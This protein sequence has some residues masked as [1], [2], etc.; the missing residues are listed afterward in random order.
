M[1][2]HLRTKAVLRRYQIGLYLAHTMMLSVGLV[3]C[4]AHAQWITTALLIVWLSKTAR[5]IMGHNSTLRTPLRDLVP[6]TIGYH[7]M[8]WRERLTLIPLGILTLAQ[9]LAAVYGAWYVAAVIFLAI[10]FLLLV[11][12]PI[13]P[14]V[15]LV[16]DATADE[17]NLG[18]YPFISVVIAGYFALQFLGFSMFI[19]YLS[20]EP[21]LLLLWML[22]VTGVL[23]DRL[24][25]LKS[26]P[27]Q[28][29]AD[30]DAAVEEFPRDQVPESVG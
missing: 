5:K 4:F 11:L 10:L 17:R 20:R 1:V 19:A 9:L 28:E 3:L 8:R 12:F 30:S 23:K 29:P 13:A 18:E 16:I 26:E 15:I 22:I 27:S 2:F 6:F 14:A 25:F 21:W 24:L 7:G